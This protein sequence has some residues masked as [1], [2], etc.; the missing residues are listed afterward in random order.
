MKLKPSE[1]AGWALLFVFL[2]LAMSNLAANYIPESQSGMASHI[3][4]AVT[5]LA[6]FGL[7]T[8]IL[9]RY[10]PLQGQVRLRGK[11]FRLYYL[12]FV[13]CCT[14][15]ISFLS[16]LL[17]FFSSVWSGG[18]AQSLQNYYP[19]SVS[20]FGGDM[21][22]STVTVAL[23]PAIAEEFFMRG[24]V[25]SL[26]EKRGTTA[27]VLL[28]A[29][30]FS[31]LHSSPDALLPAFAAGI[32]YALLVHVTGSVWSAVAAHFLNNLYSIAITVLA[33]NYSFN[34]YWSYF[35]AAN[36]ILF[37]LFTYLALR[38]LY[39]LAFDDRLE[40]VRRTGK[41]LT[42]CLSG[43]MRAPGF[44]L[45]VFCFAFRLCILVLTGL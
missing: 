14:F 36:V 30:S 32:G 20:G 35:I 16:F 25:Y 12:P 11:P 34:D 17:S 38:A 28:S 29:L 22:L 44:L 39:S 4:L 33:V 40:A 43:A 24:A 2:M 45:F 6:A 26:Y 21:L 18:D 1:L 10:R 27:A 37:F 7:P 8:V 41:R 9:T 15:C 19:V 5:E 3:L 23:I 42:V 13:L 31:L